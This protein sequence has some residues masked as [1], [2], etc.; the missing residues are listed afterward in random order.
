MHRFFVPPAALKNGE[1]ELPEPAA[2]Q[3]RQ[4]LR[5]SAGDDIN[6]FDG[7]GAEWHV[8]LTSVGRAH[9]RGRVVEEIAAGREPRTHITLYQGLLKSDRFEWVLQ[10]CTELGVAEFVPIISARVVAGPV[11]HNKQVRWERILVEA[12]EQSGRARVP[13]LKAAISLAEGLRLARSRGGVVLIPWEQERSTDLGT[14][15]APEGPV[16]LFIGPEG[17]FT[18]DEIELAR[19]TSA[20]PITLGSR[21]LRAETAGLVAASAIFFVRGDLGAHNS[22]GNL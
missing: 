22:R 15:L 10:K 12:A 21:I 9:A 14:A 8:Q 1:V 19:S 5:L 6:I 7:S 17:G 2:R 13:P 18:E 11:S 4:V 16:H 3:V 20:V